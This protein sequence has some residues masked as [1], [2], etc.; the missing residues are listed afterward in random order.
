MAHRRTM[1]QTSNEANKRTANTLAIINDLFKLTRDA[2][3]D[4]ERFKILLMLVG[5]SEERDEVL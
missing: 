3:L 1:T 2:N 5:L 4:E